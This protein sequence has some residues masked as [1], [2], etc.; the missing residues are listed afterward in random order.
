VIAQLATIPTKKDIQKSRGAGN[1]C[2]QEQYL[3][4]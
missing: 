4:K 3:K 2:D 1:G